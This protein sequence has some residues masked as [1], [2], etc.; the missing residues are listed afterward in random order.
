M[1]TQSKSTNVSQHML[2]QILEQ[3]DGLLSAGEVLYSGHALVVLLLTII[4]GMMSLR[5]NSETSIDQFSTHSNE[6]ETWEAFLL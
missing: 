1:S 3:I 4:S 2:V 5:A 6:T